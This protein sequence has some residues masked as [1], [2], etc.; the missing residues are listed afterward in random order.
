MR[1]FDS[2]PPP[3]DAAR[4]MRQRQRTFNTTNQQSLSRHSFAHAQSAGSWVRTLCARQRARPLNAAR[5]VHQRQRALQRVFLSE[6]ALDERLQLW[7]TLQ[8]KN[9]GR[10]Q[11]AAR[12][13]L[14]LWHGARAKQA[15]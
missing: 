10:R 3:L 13:V 8:R 1:A 5:L 6:L 9:G 7:R 15:G 2:M 12:K 14:A 4:L 11:I